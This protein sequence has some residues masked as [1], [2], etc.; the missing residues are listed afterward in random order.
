MPGTDQSS[1]LFHL[2]QYTAYAVLC[3]TPEIRRFEEKKMKKWLGYFCIGAGA[4]IMHIHASGQY[5]SGTN[6]FLQAG[7]AL[8]MPGG[9]DMDNYYRTGW[10][11]ELHVVTSFSKRSKLSR[12][13][14][15]ANTGA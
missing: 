11:G 7:F 3:A 13:S 2:P 1:F 4:L 10:G 6:I 12:L 15:L 8:P 5:K 9:G 14:F